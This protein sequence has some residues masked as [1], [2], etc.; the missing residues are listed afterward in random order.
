V[1][2]YRKLRR[3]IAPGIEGPVNDLKNSIVIQ[4][5]KAKNNIQKSYQII[6][7]TQKAGLFLSS[8]SNFTYLKT[9]C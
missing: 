1:I 6:T 8:Q 9:K 2:A 4:K 3:R 5:I 7:G